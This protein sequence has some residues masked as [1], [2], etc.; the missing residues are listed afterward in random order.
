VSSDQLLPRKIDKKLNASLFVADSSRQSLFYAKCSRVSVVSNIIATMIY[1]R[2]SVVLMSAGGRAT[3]LAILSAV[4]ACATLRTAAMPIDVLLLPSFMSVDT[5]STLGWSSIFLRFEVFRAPAPLLSPVGLSM[6]LPQAPPPPPHSMHP[7]QSYALSQARSA[8]APM[9]YM[10]LQQPI[11]QYLPAG[12]TIAPS[13][14]Q[15][16]A[17]RR[18]AYFTD[19]ATGTT[20]IVQDAPT[21]LDVSVNA[22]VSETEGPGLQPAIVQHIL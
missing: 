14:Q 21:S 15:A 18:L 4:S 10:H 1:E 13:F 9:E 6:A 20:Y 12:T 11:M 7:A 22:F 5:T 3:H 16:G 8:P 19:A 2:G 17:H